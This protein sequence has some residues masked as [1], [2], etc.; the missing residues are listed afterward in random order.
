MDPLIQTLVDAGFIE[1]TEA[2]TLWMML[3]PADARAEAE[4]EVMAAFAQGLTAQQQRLFNLLEKSNYNPTA[5]QLSTFWGNETKK[6][7]KTVEP[8]ILDQIATAA[9]I[10]AVANGRSDWEIVASQAVEFAQ[11]YYLSPNPN[12]LGSLPNL[13][14][15]SRQ[16]FEQQFSRWLNGELPTQQGRNQYGMLRGEGI[17][18]LVIALDPTF[19]PTRAER[20]AVTETTRI[21]TQAQRVAERDIVEITHYRLLTSAD[22]RVCS[23]CGPLYGLTREKGI[24]I[25]E[26]P[27]FGPIQGPPFHPRC[28][29]EEVSETAE[30]LQIPFERDEPTRPQ[31]PATRQPS[32]PRPQPTPTPR[33]P[34][35]RTPS[36]DPV[37]PVTPVTPSTP[38]PPALQELPYEPVAIFN[39]PLPAGTAIN[40]IELTS[41]PAPEW[42]TVPDKPINEQPMQTAKR[43]ASGVVMV[44]P[45]GR[46]WVV[47]PANHY[48]GVLH[49]YPKGGQATGLTLQQ[50]ALK[51]VF[52]ETGLQVEITDLLGDYEGSTSTTR[53]YVGKRTG[54]APWEFDKETWNVKLATP[55]EL[56]KMLNQQRDLDVL[57]DL[58]VKMGWKQPPAPPA[59][60]PSPTPKQTDPIFE[61]EMTPFKVQEDVDVDERGFPS[62]RRLTELRTVKRLGG[63]TGAELVEDPKS[64]KR[65]VRKRGNSPDHLREEAISDRAY[66][67]LGLNV[68]DFNLY[69]TDGGPVKLAEFIEGKTL[70]ELRG[71][72]RAAYNRAVAEMKRGLAADALMGNWDVVGAGFDNVL[73]DKDGT[74]WRIDNGGSLRFRAQGE[75]KDDSIFGDQPFDLWTLRD[76]KFANNHEVFGDVG[77][78]EIGRQIPR[79]EA[80]REEFLAGLPKELR[81]R[82]AARLDNL[83]HVGQIARTFESDTW[84]E[85]YTDDFARQVFNLRRSGIVDRMPSLAGE[86]TEGNDWVIEDENGERWDHLRTKGKQKS[87]IHD[88]ADVMKA[89]GGDY[90][91]ITYWSERQG[92]SSWSGASQ[93]AK[94]WY[95]QHRSNNPQSDYYW[96]EGYNTAQN[97]LTGTYK[98]V[99]QEKYDRTLTMWHAFNYEFLQKADFRNN[100]RD[101]G[102][103]R[104]F[105]TEGSDPMF[106]YHGFTPGAFGEA[107]IMQRGAV[108]SVS[109]FGDVYIYGDHVTVQ[110]VPHHRF[111]GLYFFE[112][113]PGSGSTLYLGDNENEGLAMLEGITA[114][115]LGDRSH[116]L[117]EPGEYKKKGKSKKK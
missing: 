58:E 100:Y 47:E 71:N 108:E 10:E 3:S 106:N 64:G 96:H 46:I 103:V 110:D 22:D 32:T 90:S 26:H 62:T 68:P 21:F 89:E 98:T 35:T 30:T 52:E 99:G 67:A 50:S 114:N 13:N 43:K 44:E 81:P 86:W 20:I 5:K 92:G 74:V 61:K 38:A 112:R 66:R 18:D 56:R 16:Q 53:Y 109:L 8:T 94:M 101:E 97:H 91:I 85:G 82:M 25:W 33:Q 70:S 51:E 102:F 107:G 111:M 115:Y 83:A 77:I 31:Q 48:G 79:L 6:F 60:P 1:Y 12:N 28:R 11:S 41:Q 95:A 15:T 36:L 75:R 93:A 17:A 73:V 49:T 72:D 76:P 7:W 14:Q 27:R 4:A 9:S 39:G 69:E 40:G 29:C 104:V 113:S 19:G 78:F 116:R 59:P 84:Q 34:R 117:I 2:T 63:S 55:D 24:L 45:D 87:V 80:A 57:D 54:G 37:T 105:R 42:A 23:I 65:F 88:L